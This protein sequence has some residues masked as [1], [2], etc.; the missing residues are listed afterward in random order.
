VNRAPRTS[1]R[2]V[3]ERK[4]R[5]ERE[6]KEAAEAADTADTTETAVGASKKSGDD[7]LADPTSENSGEA[8]GIKPASLIKP[9]GGRRNHSRGCNGGKRYSDLPSLAKS[10]ST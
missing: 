7:G 1:P 2:L 10:A 9:Q 3:A 6:R 8:A 5:R 4:R